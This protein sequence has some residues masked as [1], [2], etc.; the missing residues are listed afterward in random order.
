MSKTIIIFFIVLLLI[1]NFSLGISTFV[2][3]ETDLV[4]LQPKAEDPDA[5]ELIYSYAAP[6]NE[7]GEWQT[8]YGD[9]GEYEVTITVS[10]GITEVSQDVLI[11]VNRKEEKPIIES[12]KPENKEV[13]IK[14]GQG[15]NFQIIASDLNKDSLIIKWLLNDKEI[16][17]GDKFSFSASYEDAGKYKVKVTVSDGTSEVINEWNLN[18]EDVNI[19]NILDTIEDITIEETQLASLKLPNFEE[20][21]LTYE[22]SEPLK[23]NKWQ[24]SY[25]DAG[26][27]IVTIA[28]EGKG[29]S[30]SK[31]VKVT[32]TNKDRPP[33]FTKL[34]DITVNEGEEAK[35]VLE[36]KDPDEDEIIYSVVDIPSG[37]SFE[38]N[39]FNLKTDFDFVKKENFFDY[40]LDKFRILRKTV[41]ITFVASSQESQTERKVKITVKDV[42]RPFV[43]EPIAPI[44]VN[45]GEEI[46]IN[47]QYNDPDNDLVRFSYSGAIN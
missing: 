38:G 41:K 5:Q 34:N 20:L 17:T 45:E 36:A 42:N 37:A 12:F 22:I 7:N 9:V 2:Y 28:V 1:I 11:I 47:P 16:S 19:E 13:N 29:F 21:S 32:V 33:E 25:D 46:V 4:S 14:E 31:E 44:E 15:I 39:V 24:T 30:G 35:I 6:L 3:N 26:E 23:T 10:D 8:T 43:L 40:V 18:V 27:Y